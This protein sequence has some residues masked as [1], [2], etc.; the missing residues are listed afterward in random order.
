MPDQTTSDRTKKQ[1]RAVPHFYQRMLSTTP[2]KTVK[3][4]IFNPKAHKRS[5]I[6]QFQRVIAPKMIGTYKH[7]IPEAAH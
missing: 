2:P 7:Q 4:K 3:L 1:N 6:F 5:F